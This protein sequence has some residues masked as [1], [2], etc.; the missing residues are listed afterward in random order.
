M[1]SSDK[2]ICS[3]QVHAYVLRATA[4]GAKKGLFGTQEDRAFQERNEPWI[5]PDSAD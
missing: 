1:P 3:K 5:S 2:V 4:S